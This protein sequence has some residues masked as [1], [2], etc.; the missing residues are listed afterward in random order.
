MTSAT[1][2]RLDMQVKGK[3]D[4]KKEELKAELEAKKAEMLAL[5]GDAQNGKNMFYDP[6]TPQWANASQDTRVKASRAGCFSFAAFVFSAIVFIVAVLI[7]MDLMSESEVVKTVNDPS[8]DTYNSLAG[9]EYTDGKKGL[10]CECSQT[11]V[12][13]SVVSSWSYEL[14]SI[15]GVEQIMVDNWT[16]KTSAGTEKQLSEKMYDFW[17]EMRKQD[18]TLSMALVSSL[19]KMGSMCSV[20]DSLM[21]NAKAKFEATSLYTPKV[22]SATE[23]E[24]LVSAFLLDPDF[25]WPAFFDL[26]SKSLDIWGSIMRPVTPDTY[27]GAEPID[28]NEW[29]QMIGDPSDDSFNSYDD[30]AE[31]YQS[32]FMGSGGVQGKTSG[33]LI[34]ETGYDDDNGIELPKSPGYGMSLMYDT[35]VFKRDLVGTMKVDDT[36]TVSYEA[37]EVMYCNSYRTFMNYPVKAMGEQLTTNNPS[38]SDS[39]VV[40]QMNAKVPGYGDLM[41]AAREM[42]KDTPGE[43]IAHMMLKS[44][45]KDTL[46]VDH[47]AHYAQCAPATCTYLETESASGATVF[48]ILVGIYGG[49]HAF[50]TAFIFPFLVFPFFCVCFRAMTLQQWGRKLCA[51]GLD[52]AGEAGEEY[53]GDVAAQGA[54]MAEGKAASFAKEATQDDGEGEQ[55]KKRFIFF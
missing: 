38:C 30:K 17:T 36:C 39:T 29:T 26:H 19:S 43:L 12:F 5:L 25:T 13:A 35:A 16:T 46:T 24:V 44:K 4:A 15:C 6:L 40:S 49:F 21:A 53:A 45:A 27:N 22:L 37:E 55:K 3:F 28:L 47:E 1:D 14:D 23:L 34:I 10:V 54:D 20:S 2:V 50:S 8:Y 18:M 31:F 11:S 52:E 41:V 48:A 9:D 33:E 51:F 7:P 32:C 42:S